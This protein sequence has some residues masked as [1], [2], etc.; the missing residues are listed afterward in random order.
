MSIL[1]TILEEI[2]DA[3]FILETYDR[4]GDCV[5][6]MTGREFVDAVAHHRGAFSGWTVP[7]GSDSASQSASQSASGSAEPRSKL[8]GLL[9]KSEETIEFLVAAFAAIAEGFTVVPLSP[10]WTA[11]LQ[12]RYL[13][14]YKIRA[15]AAGAGLVKRVEEWG[16]DRVVTVSVAENFPSAAAGALD[17]PDNLPESRP[18]A[19]I[20][21]SGTSGAVPKCTVISMNNIAAAIDNI[22][23]LDFL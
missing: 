3:E 1:R 7:G 19:W 4:Q 8:V 9:F 5:L 21:T 2:R 14:Q 20:F 12:L 15:M 18:C 6:K 16:L 10:N 22:K 23:K 17:Y 13:N 11:E